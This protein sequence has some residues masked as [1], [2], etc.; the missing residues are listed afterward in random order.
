MSERC[1]V[2]NLAISFRTATEQAREIPPLVQHT[3]EAVENTRFDRAH[4]LMF[5]DYALKYEVVYYVLSAD[6]KLY[7]DIQQ[8][9][10]FT[11]L[12]ELRQRDIQ[13]AMPVRALEFLEEVPLA[14]EEYL[15]GR[16]CPLRRGHPQAL[17]V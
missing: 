9:I 14:S 1:V 7:M 10:N 11:L 6:Y 13:F 2:F 3:I 15:S 17:D 8:A 12:E 16:Q 5:D 4:L